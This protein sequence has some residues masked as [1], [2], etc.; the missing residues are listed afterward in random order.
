M[1]PWRHAAALLRYIAVALIGA[2]QCA[3]AHQASVSVSSFTFS[4]ADVLDIRVLEAGKAGVWFLNWDIGVQPLIRRTARVTPDAFK[5]PGLYALCLD[6]RLIYVG[7]YLGAGREGAHFTGDVATS[8]W[9]TH[10]GAI[11]AR[12]SRVHIT[13]GSLKALAQS[14]GPDHPMVA[15]LLGASEPDLLQKDQGNLAPLRRLQ[16]AGAQGARLFDS[17]VQPDEVLKRFTFVYSRIT[18]P[19]RGVSSQNLKSRVETAEQGLIARYS[20][21]C[22]TKH[23]A[24]DA[25]PVE[26]GCTELPSLLSFALSEGR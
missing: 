13:R 15:G 20:P 12:G 22:N 1:G 10:I 9:W 23:V 11:T 26:L 18:A 21:A 25:Q 7:S 8:R 14:P 5:G 3:G 16:F 4:A 19:P 24:Q 2:A 17:A 6:D